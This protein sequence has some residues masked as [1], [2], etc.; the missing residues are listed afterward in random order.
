[1]SRKIFLEDLKAFCIAALIK[2]GMN[3][4]NAKITAEVLAE[5]DSFGTH[6]HGT[7]NLFDYIRKVEAGGMKINGDVK[8]V[9]DGPAFATID[10]DNSFG[11]VPAHTGMSLAI[12]KAQQSGISCVLVKNA[13]H[14]GAA[15]YYSLMA[16]KAG[17]IGMVCSNVDSNMGIPGARGKVL[18]N[19]PFSYAVPTGEK[20]PVFLDIAMS[21]VA[22]LKVIQ[23]KKDGQ[24]IPDSWI[25]DKDGLPTTDPSNYPDEGAMQPMAGHK[26]YGLSLLVEILTGVLSGGSVM[27]EIPSWL[28]NME[29]PNAVSHLCIVINPKM[30]GSVDIFNNRMERVVDELH[31]KPLAKGNN[32]IYYPGEIEW[33][34]HNSAKK[35]GIPLPGDVADSLEKLSEKTGIKIEWI[36]E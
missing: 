23:A 17:M 1:M 34:R 6:S 4:E 19:S 5:T 11:M 29:S 14:F 18:G 8:V 21:T 36:K 12:E 33:L 25:T 7:K 31:S 26:G 15:G 32:K 16:A 35:S 28:F 24:S 30:F 2:S 3:E 27:S 20:D 13:S 22:S 9:A 10:A